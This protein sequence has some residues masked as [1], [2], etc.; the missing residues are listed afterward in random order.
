M[1]VITIIQP[2]ASL[3][4]LGEKMI[5]TRSW[6]TKYRGEILIH[7]GKQIDKVSMQKE[8]YLK[9]LK[10]HGIENAEQLPTGVILAK[11]KIDR[12]LKMLDTRLDIV[13]EEHCILD[14]GAMGM[15][16]SGQEYKFGF[17]E[18]N[19]YGWILKDI[20]QIEHIPVRGKLGLWNY[21]Y[22]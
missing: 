14:D 11:C 2:W 12:C 17:Y 6:A 16:V 19:R 4:A 13:E 20:E 7:A 10:K 22:K 21:E 8:E 1:K 15:V 18:A 3:I 9:V 5:E